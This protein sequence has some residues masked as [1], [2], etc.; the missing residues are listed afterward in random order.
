MTSQIYNQFVKNQI[1]QTISRIKPRR[2]KNLPSK[3]SQGRELRRI[4]NIRMMRD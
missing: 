4:L 3:Y 2:R 1:Q